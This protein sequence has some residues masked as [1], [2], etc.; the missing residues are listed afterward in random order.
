MIPRILESGVTSFM[1]V[2]DLLSLALT[3]AIIMAVLLVE[4]EMFSR[5]FPVQVNHAMGIVTDMG[6]LL[7]WASIVGIVPPLVAVAMMA[8]AALAGVPVF[9]WYWH[10]QEIGRQQRAAEAQRKEDAHRAAW[11]KLYRENGKLA[12]RVARLTMTAHPTQ[13]SRAHDLLETISFLRGGIRQDLNDLAVLVGQL[14]P[15]LK[16][17]DGEE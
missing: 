4:H 7:L 15:L 3:V 14:E 6:G 17:V 9:A 10:E 13:Y 16:T 8:A 2:D 11:E 12:G 5:R 1:G